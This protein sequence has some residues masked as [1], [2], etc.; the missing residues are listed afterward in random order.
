MPQSIEKKKG[1]TMERSNEITLDYDISY[2]TFKR[3][4]TYKR[5]MQYV[6]KT[7][8]VRGAYIRRSATGNTHVKL[9]LIDEIPFFDR[10]LLRAYL[11]EDAY[12]I[13]NDLS[14]YYQGKHTDVIFDSKVITPEWKQKQ[15]LRLI[16]EIETCRREI[17]K[18]DHMPVGENKAGGWVSLK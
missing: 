15:L 5:L 14:R 1:N 16:K 9:T 17:T 2:E 7:V 18:I 12:R 13:V 3:S 11:R 8:I 4:Y 10:I 6:N